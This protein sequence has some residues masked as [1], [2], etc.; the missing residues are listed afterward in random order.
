MSVVIPNFNRGHLLPGAVESVL[1]Q[2]G[3][4]LEV[5]VCDDGSADNSESVV[6]SLC[7]SRVRWIPGRHTGGPSAPRNRGIAAASGEWIAFLDSDD[8]WCEGKL[9]AQLL[10]LRATGA[11][12]CVTNAYRHI[13]G[14]ER[15][16]TLLHDRLPSPIR[17]SQQLSANLVITSSVVVRVNTLR[18]VGGFPEKPARSIFEDYALWLRLAQIE[19][20]EVVQDPLVNYRDCPASSLRGAMFPE[21]ACTAYALLDFVRWRNTQV[22][23]IATSVREYAVMARQLA[24]LVS[25]R[26]IWSRTLRSA[27]KTTAM[28]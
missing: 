28:P 5:L 9:E 8:T 14:H 7:D 21:V 13:P 12:T 2:T 4:E 15:D 11:S 22:A 23:P 24:R 26:D 6:K 3:V 19:P 20:I 17:L 16:A 18:G 27:T 1:R 25:L 10:L